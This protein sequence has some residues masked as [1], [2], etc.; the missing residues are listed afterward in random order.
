MC[1]RPPARE[2]LCVKMVGWRSGTFWVCRRCVCFI[3][4]Y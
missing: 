1:S 4:S 3:L 2:F